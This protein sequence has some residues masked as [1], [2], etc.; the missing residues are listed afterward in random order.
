[1]ASGET[2]ARRA[3]TLPRQALYLGKTAHRIHGTH[4]R[5]APSSSRGR[6]PPGRGLSI[7]RRWFF[8]EWQQ[9]L[10]MRIFGLKRFFGL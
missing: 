2:T 4:I 5:S 7:F 1:M 6:W 10:L 9:M 3:G 8:I